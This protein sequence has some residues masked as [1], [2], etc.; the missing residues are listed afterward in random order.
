MEIFGRAMLNHDPVPVKHSWSM[1]LY[2]YSMKSVADSRQ[3]HNRAFESKVWHSASWCEDI[4]AGLF[5]LLTSS[6][7]ARLAQDDS[8]QNLRRGN[9]NTGIPRVGIINNSS[10]YFN[11]NARWDDWLNISIVLPIR[12]CIIAQS[13]SFDVYNQSFILRI[14]LRSWE[15]DNASVPQVR[16]YFIQLLGLH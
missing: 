5:L 13:T 3:K 11:T 15:Y 9:N 16:F 14:H 1:L 6:L 7:Q 12:Q 2:K 8:W 4:R 10:H